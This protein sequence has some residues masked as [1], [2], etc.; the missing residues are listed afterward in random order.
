MPEL[1]C[2]KDWGAGLNIGRWKMMS[3]LSLKV[4]EL[5]IEKD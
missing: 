3:Y 4:L 1:P 5:H 2:G